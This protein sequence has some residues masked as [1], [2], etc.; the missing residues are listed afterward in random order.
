MLKIVTDLLEA[1]AQEEEAN[2][3]EDAAQEQE[4]TNSETIPVVYDP[5]IVKT[6]GR[7]KRIKGPLE[8]TKKRK[9]NSTTIT[10]TKK[11][12]TTNTQRKEFGAKTPIPRL[13]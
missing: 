10:N 5:K 7:N 12:K 11:K 1:A 3:N 6:K 4:A 9:N 8:T 13:F 2:S